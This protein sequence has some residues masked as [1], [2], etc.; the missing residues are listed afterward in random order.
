MFK[1]PDMRQY[2][3]FADFIC[4]LIFNVLFIMGLGLFYSQV[5]E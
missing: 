4:C 1:M 3:N 2:R 5:T